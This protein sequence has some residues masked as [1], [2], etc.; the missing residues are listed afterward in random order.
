MQGLMLNDLIND[1]QC[2]LKLIG[3]DQVIEERWGSRDFI[4]PFG[5]GELSQ[6]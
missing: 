3:F 1:H 6:D 2:S 5:H 4:S